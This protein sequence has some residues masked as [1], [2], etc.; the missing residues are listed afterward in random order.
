MALVVQIAAPKHNMSQSKPEPKPAT[1]YDTMTPIATDK[2][3]FATRW[4][5]SPRHIDNLMTEGLP[6][7]KIG[8]RRVRIVVEEADRWMKEKFGVRRLGSV[9]RSSQAAQE[10]TA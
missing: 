10:T 8:R 1:T 6:H 5:F 7:L 2:K 3:G 4:G 9:C